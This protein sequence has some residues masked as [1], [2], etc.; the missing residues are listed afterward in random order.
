VDPDGWTIQH[1]PNVVHNPFAN[2]RLSGSTFDGHRQL[3]LRDT[4]MSWLEK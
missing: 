1:V 4:G 3:V 2:V